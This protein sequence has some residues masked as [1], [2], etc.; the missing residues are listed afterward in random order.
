MNKKNKLIFGILCLSSSYI[1]ATS[2]PRA[3]AFTSSEFCNSFKSAAE[4]HCVSSG[5]PRG[6]CTNYRLLYKRMLD[7]FGSL[8]KACEFQK[9]TSTQ[10]CIDDWNCFLSGGLA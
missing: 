10:E 5:F 2:C 9:E 1:F 6:M 4:C 8:Q 3:T 7:T